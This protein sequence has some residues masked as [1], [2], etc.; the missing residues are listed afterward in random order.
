MRDDS[1][2]QAVEE[3][4]RRFETAWQSEERRPTISRYLPPPATPLREAVLA[5]LVKI[6]QHWRW[7]HGEQVLL[8]TYLEE[9]PELSA[10]AAVVSD[11]LHAECAVRAARGAS[12]TL[13]ELRQRF[14]E[15][16]QS[17]DLNTIVLPAGDAPAPDSG[18]PAPALAAEAPN[19]VPAA[20]DS[21][22]P[23]H[24]SWSLSP[25]GTRVGRYE[26]RAL[27]GAGGMGEVYRAYDTELQREVALKIP[28]V[29]PG[30]KPDVLNRFVEEA[31]A[32]ASLRHPHIC[33]VY[34][35]GQIGDRYFI[36]MALIE[37]S[38]L[39]EKL[40]QGACDPALS[41]RIVAQLAR[42]LDAAHAN[43]IV[44]RDIKPANVMLDAAEQ[45]LL[46]DFGLA[47]RSEKQT[48]LT[49]AGA[50]LGTPAYM[51]P[52]QA[53]MQPLDHRTDIY[54][55][56]VVLYQMLTGQL[57]YSGPPAQLPLQIAQGKPPKPTKLRP[58]LDPALEAICLRAMAREAEQRYQTAGELAVALEAFLAPAGS[59]TGKPHRALWAALVLAI[60]LLMG[61]FAYHMATQRLREGEDA[62]ASLPL[63]ARQQRIADLEQTLAKTATFAEDLQQVRDL[64]E[65]Y[66]QVKNNFFAANAEVVRGQS[67]LALGR[68]KL[69]SMSPKELAVVA[70]AEQMLARTGIN[71][72]PE[73]TYLLVRELAEMMDVR[74]SAMAQEVTKLTADEHRD[75]EA[76]EP[77]DATPEA[78]VQLPPDVVAR[79]ELARRELAGIQSAEQDIAEINQ[80]DRLQGELSQA[81]FRNLE[82]ASLAIRCQAH[83]GR[84]YACELTPEE[85]TLVDSCHEATVRCNSFSLINRV[86][87]F[88]SKVV[89]SVGARL[90]LL[91]TKVAGLEQ[92]SSETRSFETLIELR[93]TEIQ[94]LCDR[95]RIEAGTRE[96]RRA[97]E[98]LTAAVDQAPE[99]AA[100]YVLRAMLQIQQRNLDAAAADCE[101]ALTLEP[102]M[103]FAYAVRSS[104]HCARGDFTLAVGDCDHAL[105]IDPRITQ[106]YIT[107]AAVYVAS[108]AFD[109]AVTDAT[110]A[111]AL[112]PH[113]ADALR[114]RAVAQL[115]LQ[116]PDKALEDS[117][118]AVQLA[119]LVAEN[120][121]AH[122]RVLIQQQ[123]QQDAVG[124][125]TEALRL[126][127]ATGE[128]YRLRSACYE[129]LSDPVRAAT[130]GYQANEL[131]H[132]Q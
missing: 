71:N 34:D 5:R 41:A 72:V 26:I 83:L 42:A 39:A 25:A 28:R 47:R 56:G 60:L 9:W 8:E 6:D 17:A 15:L 77:A 36:V 86:Y 79:L 59:V 7:Q 29:S 88:V 96:Y 45:P 105:Q 82:R 54:S 90:A 89:L 13:D 99:D 27:L 112:E 69:Y 124:E 58:D 103:A 102:D 120:H 55:L 21:T 43:G 93:P 16:G 11:L 104:I 128:M 118:Q 3:I 73:D 76:P 66:R 50:F 1:V 100:L 125:L 68:L 74:F 78:V 115:E 101:R 40:D 37:G 51:S 127:P 53:A 81:M 24:A 132:K 91:K 52:E 2:R 19:T 63:T 114:I 111:L 106:A 126:G 48:H 97:V 85:T 110:A 87:P 46:T 70:L 113:A 92:W 4:A 95:A 130:D 64:E 35:A 31:L 84:I 109:R 129:A 98:T 18:P 14:P 80:L 75:A 10:N 122:A 44:H 12:S 94:S 33:P 23:L 20:D 123:L 38:T 62:G 22:P 119:P 61:G 30:A 107:R 108:G 65:P 117:R 57:P 131:E 32:A 121:L 49:V 67:A 116:A